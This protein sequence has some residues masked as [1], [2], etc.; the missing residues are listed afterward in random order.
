MNIIE[1]QT[2][3]QTAVHHVI[4]DF[5]SIDS[6]SPI[7]YRLQFLNSCQVTYNTDDSEYLTKYVNSRI[8]NISQKSEDLDVFSV[9]RIRNISIFV[10]IGVNRRN[11]TF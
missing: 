10:C 4:L 9:L 8:Y 2:D 1:R 5:Y 11:K 3:S 7:K 6:V